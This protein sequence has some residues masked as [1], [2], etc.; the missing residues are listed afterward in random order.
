M[1]PWASPAPARVLLGAPGQRWGH[2]AQVCP[3]TSPRVLPPHSQKGFGF[4]GSKFHRVIK[5]FMIQGG[6]FTRGDG[7][8]GNLADPSPCL[9]VREQPQFQ[10]C[11]AVPATSIKLEL[12]G[13]KWAWSSQRH[14]LAA[15]LSA[16]VTGVLGASCSSPLASHPCSAPG[17]LPTPCSSPCLMYPCGI[18]AS[19]CSGIA[20]FPHPPH[21]GATTTITPT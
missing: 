14:G 6:D 1:A 15:E 20:H 18:S 12:G 9:G 16:G 7:T 11:R 3:F 19:P 2:G 10:H 5:D 13:I 8:G 17:V 21:A 4:K